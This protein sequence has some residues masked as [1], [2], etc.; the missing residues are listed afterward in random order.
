[1]PV[2]WLLGLALGV[3]VA[4]AWRVA[5]VELE[6]EAA[7]RWFPLLPV[8]DLVDAALWACSLWGRTV[9][10]R[11]QRYRLLEE[12]KIERVQRQCHANKGE[13]IWSAGARHRFL[14]P[15]WPPETFA[16]PRRW[17]VGRHPGGIHHRDEKAVASP[18]TPNRLALVCTVSFERLLEIGVVVSPHSCG[19]LGP[20]SLRTPRRPCRRPH[21]AGAYTGRTPCLR[22]SG[23][24]GRRDP[25]PC[26]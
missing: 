3:R 8:S 11:G 6:S 16:C 20:R 21:G 23:G 13:T 2:R 22:A 4:A 26:L 18:R 10:W 5:V 25:S 15:N 1:M 9:L 12:G 19:C 17:C 7:R 14:T 24:G